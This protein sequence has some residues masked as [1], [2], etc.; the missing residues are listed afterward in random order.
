MDE[1]PWDHE[2]NGLLILS[3]AVEALWREKIAKGRLLEV[4]R[5]LDIEV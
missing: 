1:T 5:L 2:M 3:L 4:G